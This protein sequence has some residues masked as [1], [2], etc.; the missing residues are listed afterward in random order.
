[1]IKTQRKWKIHL[2]MEIKFISSKDSDKTRIMHSNSDD[3]KIMMGSG[4][5]ESLK[6]YL[7][8][9]CKFIKKV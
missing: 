1:M 9:F 5:D 2:A 4:T 7:N 8:L 3:I 6:N